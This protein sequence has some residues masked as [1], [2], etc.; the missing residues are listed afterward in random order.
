MET[1]MY[2]AIS[3]LPVDTPDMG[4]IIL[5]TDEVKQ[6]ETWINRISNL[7]KEY[8]NAILIKW[9]NWILNREEF[10]ETNSN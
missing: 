9:G 3:A 2:A 1:I 8:T 10:G 5:F 6:N 7:S 4:I